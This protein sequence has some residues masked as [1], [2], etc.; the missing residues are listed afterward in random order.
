MGADGPESAVEEEATGVL[1]GA[2]VCCCGVAAC[3]ACEGVVEG[4]VEDSGVL[5]GLLLAAFLPPL[6]F[7]SPADDPAAPPLFPLPDADRN[8]TSEQE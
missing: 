7:A 3:A 5:E 2:P 1:S 6:S 8:T 4:L